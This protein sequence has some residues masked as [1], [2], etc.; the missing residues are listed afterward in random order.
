MPDV[1]FRM[2]GEPLLGGSTPPMPTNVSVEGLY[3]HIAE[4]PLSEAD[5]WLYTSAWD[6]VP[7]QLLEVSMTGIPLV[8][9]LVGGTGE[10]LGEHD[11][12]P[13]PEDRG[14]EAYVEAIRAALADPAESRCRAL[15]L[16]ERM[17]R[18]RTEKEFAT[19][20]ADLLFG[21]RT[22]EEAGR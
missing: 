5:V 20:A 11:S 13:V 14:A 2:W 8:G 10:V 22:T 21:D 4:I 16:R 19:R 1:D 15:A 12:W 9:T 18:E 6:G 3:R 7:S 17:L